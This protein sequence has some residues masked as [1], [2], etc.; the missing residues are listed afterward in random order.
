MMRHLLETE[1]AIL[2][3]LLLFSLPKRCSYL[4]AQTRQCNIFIKEQNL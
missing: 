1:N 3:K 4:R 2:Q